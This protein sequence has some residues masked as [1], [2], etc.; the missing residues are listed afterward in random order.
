M[1][2]KSPLFTTPLLIA[3]GHY[4]KFWELFAV[5]AS[6]LRTNQNVIS[7]FLRFHI[8]PRWLYWDFWTINSCS[9]NHPTV[10]WVG[11]HLAWR[12]I[13]QRIVFHHLVVWKDQS[14]SCSTGPPSCN[15]DGCHWPCEKTQL[16]FEGINPLIAVRWPIAVVVGIR[17]C[18]EDWPFDPTEQL[19]VFAIFFWIAC[20]EW[21]GKLEIV[22]MQWLIGG[23]CWWC[24]I[25]RTS[26]GR[27]LP[28]KVLNHKR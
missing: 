23:Q 13:H 22:Y 3:G 12:M 25:L 27:E 19:S 20:H 6:K 7:L 10:K 17:Q 9:K 24:S 11:Y 4:S 15:W 18:R 14:Y 16:F 5:D 21:S 8:Q 26:N 2:N 1:I 28:F